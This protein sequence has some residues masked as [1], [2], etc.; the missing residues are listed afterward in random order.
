MVGIPASRFDLRNLVTLLPL[1]LVPAH[2]Q[3]PYRAVLFDGTYAS[4]LVKIVATTMAIQSI[5]CKAP[6]T[7][8]QSTQAEKMR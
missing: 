3:S 8:F 1:A 6:P 5:V 4:P 2:A 7:A